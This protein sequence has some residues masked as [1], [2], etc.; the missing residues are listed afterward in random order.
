MKHWQRKTLTLTGIREKD[1]LAKLPVEER[2]GVG[3]AV[4]RGG[5]DA[6]KSGGWKMNNPNRRRKW[7][8]VVKE[9]DGAESV[10]YA[11]ELA[12]LGRNLLRQE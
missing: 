11:N 10:A 12:L 1:A 5:G 9:T 2:A 3:E 6:E 4:G 7:A 8:K